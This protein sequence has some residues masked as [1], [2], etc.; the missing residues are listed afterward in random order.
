M[1]NDE[2]LKEI[3]SKIRAARN[4]KGLHLRDL[5]QLVRLDYSSICRIEN[6]QYSSR[7]L[8]LLALAKALDCDVKDFL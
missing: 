6:G 8:T 2:Y 7:V 1:R 3:G 5:A 4:A